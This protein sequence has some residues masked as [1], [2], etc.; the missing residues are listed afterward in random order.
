MQAAGPATNVAMHESVHGLRRWI[1]IGLGLLLAGV[2]AAQAVRF[3]ASPRGAPGPTALQAASPAAA[4]AGVLGA[5]V[6]GTVVAAAV[7]RLVNAVVGLFVLGWGIAVLAMQTSA[8]HEVAFG[9]GSAMLLAVETLLLALVT[10]GSVV[11]VFRMAGPLRDIEPDVYGHHPHSILSLA[12]ARSAATGL[13]L[14]P[15]V[16]I[17]AQSPMKGQ[18]IAAAFLGGM[19]AGVTSRLV[20]PHV[21]PILIF[22]AAI[23]AGALGQVLGAVLTGEGLREALV[24]GRLSPLLLPMPLDIAGGA[25]AGVAIGIGWAKSFLHHDESH[26]PATARPRSPRESRVGSA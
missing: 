7:G 2:L 24:A 21:Q 10:A 13:L 6:V 26:A 25:I 5:F 8:V 14:I 15:A 20:S 3:M 19:A 22:P 18:A 12:A 17:I 4:T 1:S 23:A 11:A 16:W 9:E